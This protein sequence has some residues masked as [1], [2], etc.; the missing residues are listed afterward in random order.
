MDLIQ[1]LILA[2]IQGMTEFLPVSSSAHLILVPKIIGWND[3]GLL[4]DIALHFGTLLAVLI[5]F[6]DDLAQMIEDL[7]RNRSHNIMQSDVMILIIATIP[8][9]IVGGLFNDWIENNLRSSNVIATTSIIF[10]L[11]LL[12]SD[13]FSS[14]K[15]NLTLRIG[16]L[17]GLAQVLAL[18][19]GVSRSGITITMGL[20]MGLGRVK[21]A[22]FSFLLAIPVI[23]GA[24]VLQ[25]YESYSIAFSSI[26]YVLLLTGLSVSFLF[27]YFTIHWFL[28]FVTKVGMFPFVIY[29]IALGL[30]IFVLL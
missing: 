2:I 20:F 17:I 7:L 27:A 25:I 8:V 11:I 22:K 23:L 5:Y 30:F 28:A 24:S 19:P 29:R 26:N 1:A 3:Q 10:G 6:R 16:L 13:K 15:N 18:I 4:F 9:V 12:A 14:S 21:S